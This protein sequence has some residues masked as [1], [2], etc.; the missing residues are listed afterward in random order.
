LLSRSVR[1]ALKRCYA[2]VAAAEAVTLVAVVDLA[3]P[4]S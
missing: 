2:A 4:Q 3:V 1:S